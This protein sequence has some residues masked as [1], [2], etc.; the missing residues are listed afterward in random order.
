MRL[1]LLECTGKE[2]ALNLPTDRWPDKLTVRTT[3]AGWEETGLRSP[4]VT[5]DAEN[6]QHLLLI[7]I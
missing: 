7:L 4:L 5:A 2:K 1:K 3:R 6:R